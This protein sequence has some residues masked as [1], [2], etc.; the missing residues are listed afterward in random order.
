MDV[1]L[2][3]RL[4]VAHLAREGLTWRGTVDVAAFERLGDVLFRGTDPGRAKSSV[5][6]TAL[7]FSLDGEGRPRVRGTCKLVAPI[8]CSRCAETV[9]VEVDSRLDFRVVATDAE[10]ESLMPA[11]DVVVGDAGC[12]SLTALVE[13]DLLLS[14]P[15]AGCTD[16]GACANARDA[17]RAHGD[18]GMAAT[19]PLEA[20]GALVEGRRPA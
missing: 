7:D 11:V 5:V 3:P 9:D 6:S 18:G 1:V 19:K 4:D 10:V 8:C 16:P 12:L 13:D 20:L 2:V 15:D 14:I 17:E